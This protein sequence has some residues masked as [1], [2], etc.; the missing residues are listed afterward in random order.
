MALDAGDLRIVPGDLADD[1]VLA[2]LREHMAGMRANSPADAV[3]ALD[4]SGLV[5][6]EVSFFTAWEGEAL[7]GCGALK[8][9]TPHHGEIKSMRTAAAHLRK[10]VAAR[11]LEHLL[12]LARSR[13]YRTVSLE[14]GSGPA[15]EAALTLYRK[16]G[17]V[18]GEAFG[19]YAPSAFNQFFHLEL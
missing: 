19:E 3:Y 9:L 2:L 8:A 6:P 4:V 10:G 11:V 17:F 16:R 7:V 1:R 12:D 15:F 13:G 18:E 14:T 5:A